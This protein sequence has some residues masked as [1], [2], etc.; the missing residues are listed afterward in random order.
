MSQ[1]GYQQ[2]I[3]PVSPLCRYSSAAAAAGFIQRYL[4]AA[5]ELH[6]I[7]LRSRPPT[8]LAKMGRSV[9]CENQQGETCTA[10]Q[11]TWSSLTTTEPEVFH[12]PKLLALHMRSA[13][14]RQIR[15]SNSHPHTGPVTSTELAIRLRAKDGFWLLKLAG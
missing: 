13:S 10:Q 14:Y 6:S 15:S 7:T 3:I 1:Q 5:G 12:L 9:Y 4:N 11:V 8:I 2:T